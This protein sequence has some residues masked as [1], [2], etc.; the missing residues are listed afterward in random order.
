MEHLNKNKGLVLALKE[1]G[2]TW[3]QIARRLEV[4]PSTIYAWKKQQPELRQVGESGILDHEAENI[5]KLRLLSTPWKEI[6]DSLNV[7]VAQMKY[8]RQQ[9]G[10]ED[11][12]VANKDVSDEELEAL[13]AASAFRNPLKGALLIHAEL[14]EVGMDSCVCVWVFMCAL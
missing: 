14:H 10:Y 6:A 13:V 7:T 12:Y 9:S 5:G 8:W 3:G 2:F 4:S 11:P 1:A